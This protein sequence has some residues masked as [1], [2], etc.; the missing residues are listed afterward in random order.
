MSQKWVKDLIPSSP[1][2]CLFKQTKHKTIL[3]VR[4]ERLPL[5]LS[6]FDGDCG[7]AAEEVEWNGRVVKEHRQAEH[8][9]RCES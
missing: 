2:V 1:F 4:E 8:Q 7:S 6:L 5:S 9:P 3:E